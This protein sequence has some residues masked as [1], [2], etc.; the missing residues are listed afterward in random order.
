ML[1]NQ[2]LHQLIGVTAY[3]VDGEKLGT[4]ETVFID[5]QT[6]EPT[7]AAV[8]TG[9]F[10]SRS[11]FVPLAEADVRDGD[12]HVAH[13][14]DRVKDAPAIEADNRLDAAEE[15]ELYRYYGIPA[16]GEDE[17]AS[18]GP[19]PGDQMPTGSDLVADQGIDPMLDGPQVSTEDRLRLRRLGDPSP[20]A[21]DVRADDGGTGER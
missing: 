8:T 1:G 5:A 3:D 6:D 17:T 2:D 18:G 10:G 21:E 19:T 16:V 7:F 11:S 14:A 9:L 20:S 15:L 4:V 12:L 13:P